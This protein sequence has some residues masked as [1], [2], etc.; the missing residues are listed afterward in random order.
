MY[1]IP[2]RVGADFPQ[3]TTQTQTKPSQDRNL[4]SFMDQVLHRGHKPLRSGFFYND[5]GAVFGEASAME[6]LAQQ[7]H[8]MDEGQEIGVKGICWASR[9]GDARVVFSFTWFSRFLFHLFLR[10]PSLP[11]DRWH[12]HPP[13]P[14]HRIIIALHPYDILQL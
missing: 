12:N 11:W 8:L 14:S 10:F 9:R 3:R 6:H 4:K 1:Y 5:K 13:I 2:V 7:L